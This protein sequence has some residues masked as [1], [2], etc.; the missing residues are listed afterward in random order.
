[1]FGRLFISK[2]VHNLRTEPQI[3]AAGKKNFWPRGERAI[4]FP[5]KGLL[6]RCKPKCLVDVS[7]PLLVK[8]YL[9]LFKVRLSMRKCMFFAFVLPG[10]K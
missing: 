6:I 9:N 10:R 3:F 2:H 1:M 7:A 5:W 4:I 8:N